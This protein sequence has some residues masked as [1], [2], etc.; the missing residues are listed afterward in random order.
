MKNLK[1]YVTENLKPNKN[2]NY[3]PKTRE[4]LDDIIDELIEERG[5]NADL[6]DIDVSNITDM[7]GLFALRHKVVNFKYNKKYN[8]SRF[9]GDI[10]KWDVSN[11]ENMS[12][13]FYNSSFNG[14]IS[15]WD[16]SNVKNMGGTFM[17]SIF[18]RDI[19]KWNISNVEYMDAMF[20]NSYFIL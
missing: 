7:S 16:V 18:N 1:Q 3:V 20:S 2:N 17:H 15:K 13:M 4:E 12:D 5:N 8:F 14:D 11:V 6:N 9:N 19:Y 10:S